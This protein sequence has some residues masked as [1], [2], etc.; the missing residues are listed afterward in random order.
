MIALNNIRKSVLNWISNDSG[1]LLGDDSAINTGLLKEYIKIRVNGPHDTFCNAPHKNIFFSPDGRAVACCYNRKHI[2]GVYPYQSIK[3]IWQG[4]KKEEL[5]G[6]L[7]DNNLYSGCHYCQSHLKNKNFDAIIA[8]EYDAL[9]LNDNYP[10]K[11][12]FELSN[13]CNLECTM[14]TGDFSSL[15]RKNR[16]KEP[17]LENPYDDEF[18][19]QLEEFIPY[20]HST[21]FFGGEP[22]IIDIYYRIWEKIIAINPK[23]KIVVQT[24]A[25]VLNTKVKELLNKGNFTINVSIDSLQKSVFESIRV[26]AKFDKVMENTRYFHQYCKGKGA[27]LGISFCPMR[28]NWR[29]LPDFI[30]FCNRLDACVYFNTVWFPEELSLANWESG[31]LKEVCKYLSGFTFPDETPL[32]QHNN[33]HFT[34]FVTQVNFWYKKALKRETEK[35]KRQ[36]EEEQKMKTLEKK[37]EKLNTGVL[38]DIFYDKIRLHID[39]D[40][41]LSES[42]KRR[43]LKRYILKAD[44]V[45]GRFAETMP[46][47]KAINKLNE[48]SSFETVV[49][50]LETESEEEIYDR[51]M[52]LYNES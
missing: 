49:N 7:K 13:T 42:E 37:L 16:E 1:N 46:L 47:K 28:Q 8:K 19:R 4:E 52:V 33:K 14:C 41:N 51:V 15:I 30:N 23:C 5:R 22:F 31:I 11:L 29:E 45:F 40:E 43:K 24:N 36:E 34:D 27:H 12:E 44:N 26:N 6:H 25:T 38:K 48:E 50:I 39:C 17:Q 35:R 2:L 3:Q 18:I 32:Q 21:R 20:L 10:T 9:P